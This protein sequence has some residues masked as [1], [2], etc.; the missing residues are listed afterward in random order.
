M[1]PQVKNSKDYTKEMNAI[2]EKERKRQEDL[3]NHVDMNNCKELI[4]RFNTNISINYYVNSI[5]LTYYT[6]DEYSKG[7]IKCAVNH[8]TK[9]GYKAVSETSR[10]SKRSTTYNTDYVYD[11]SFEPS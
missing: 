3:D 2:K 9:S 11:I 8:I 7:D 10:D 4:M 1:L 5:P 6:S